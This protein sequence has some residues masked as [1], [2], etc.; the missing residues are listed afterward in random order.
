MLPMLRTQCIYKQKQKNQ[1]QEQLSQTAS[2]CQAKFSSV[3]AIYTRS[4]I[5]AHLIIF[6]TSWKSTADNSNTRDDVMCSIKDAFNNIYLELQNNPQG[7]EVC[8]HSYSVAPSTDSTGILVTNGPCYVVSTP[9]LALHAHWTT[10]ILD[11]Y[12]QS[13]KV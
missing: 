3:G 2:R 5:S 8:K 7:Q 9:L 1:L 4:P 10:S 6:F 11:G 13:V 12:L